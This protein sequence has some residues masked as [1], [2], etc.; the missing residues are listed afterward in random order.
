MGCGGDGRCIVKNDN[1]LAGLGATVTLTAV[2]FADG[3]RRALGSAQVSLPVGAGVGAWLCINGASIDNSCPS[4]GAALAS[5]GCSI[6]TCAIEAAVV[7][8]ASGAVV[9]E[10]FLLAEIP[11]NLQL[12]AATLDVSVGSPAPDGSVPV[13]V[14]S[15]AT[16]LYVQLTSQAQGRFSSNA[17]PMMGASSVVVNYLPFY[18]TDADVLAQTLRVEHLA[19]YL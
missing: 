19:Q 8:N 2:A 14:T 12:P 18:A 17:F 7:D 11:G 15:S 3:S 9:A 13:T 1:A 6:T 16:A 4:M 5:V 10:N